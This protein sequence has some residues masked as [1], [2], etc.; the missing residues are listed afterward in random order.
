MLLNYTGN[1][2]TSLSLSSSDRICSF[3]WIRGSKH[4][5]L[6]SFSNI[7]RYF[8]FLVFWQ[9][10]YLLVS[11]TFLGCVGLRFLIPFFLPFVLR[12]PCCT[13]TPMFLEHITHFLEVRCLW[14][15]G[16]RISTIILSPF[17]LSLRRFLVRMFVGRSCIIPFLLV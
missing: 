1:L 2:A 10:R 5:F 4:C 13:C 16:T 9:C 11:C 3:I 6:T 15:P 8:L 17:R 12:I 7:Y 14:K